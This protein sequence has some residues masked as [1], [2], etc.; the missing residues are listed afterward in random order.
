MEPYIVSIAAIL[1]GYLSSRIANR[2]IKGILPHIAVIFILAGAAALLTFAG[3]S[4]PKLWPPPPEKVEGQWVEKY[5]E[6]GNEF[7]AVTSIGY[8]PSTKHLEF[9]GN[10]YAKNLEVVGWWKTIQ[11]NLD[12]DQYDYLFEGDSLNL[13]KARRGHRKGVG[14][15]YF[16]SANHGQGTFLSI[17][18]DKEP[19]DFFLYRIV[20]EEAARQSR[21]NPKAFVQK[22]YD[23]PSYFNKITL[24]R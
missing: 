23:E 16:D 22:L 14:G 1:L 6:G 4:I 7:Y 21:Q 5:W 19:R 11:A 20:D 12:R 2:K 9:T 18:D 13:D 8:N 17:R 3:Q 24:S 15:I 10:A